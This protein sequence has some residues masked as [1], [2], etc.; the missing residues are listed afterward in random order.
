VKP[1][2]FAH[3]TNDM[4]IAREEIF[5]PVL[6]LLTYEDEAEAITIANDTPYGLQAYVIGSRPTAS[7]RPSSVASV[8]T[9]WRCSQGWDPNVPA[10]RTCVSVTRPDWACPIRWRDPTRAPPSSPG[11]PPRERQE[12]RC[13]PR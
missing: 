10:T 1:T 2:V 4:T 7:R 12:V 5:G 8:A 3:V 13:C 9:G 11:R 6:C